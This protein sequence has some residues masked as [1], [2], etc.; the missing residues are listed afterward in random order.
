MLPTESLEDA[1]RSVGLVRLHTKEWK[2]DPRKV[3][4]LGF[5]AGGYLVAQISTNFKHRL[6]APRDDADKETCRP[7]FAVGIYP[8]HLATGEKNLK[9]NPN[10]QVTQSTRPT[11]LV[12]AEDDFTDGINQTLTYYIALKD[13]HVPVEMHLYAQ[14]GHAFGLR[15]TELPITDWPDLMKTWLQT[16]GVLA[17]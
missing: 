16:I 12:H 8:G 7:D 9:L 11:F 4:V 10:I 2:I 17:K 13:N 5:S 14:G 1:Q 3:G 6:Y 15:H